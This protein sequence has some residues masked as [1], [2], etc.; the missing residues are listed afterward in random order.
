MAVGKVSPGT[1]AERRAFFI[2]SIFVVRVLELFICSRPKA[3]HNMRC[4][5][6][7]F[8][9]FQEQDPK[10]IFVDGLE[11]HRDERTEPRALQARDL[12]ILPHR[13]SSL[14]GIDRQQTSLTFVAQGA[15][16]SSACSSYPQ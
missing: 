16:E 5:F 15:F 4:I 1:F 11:R 14:C 7:W 9:F 3:F 13:F 12:G 6:H 2:W 8:L 10:R